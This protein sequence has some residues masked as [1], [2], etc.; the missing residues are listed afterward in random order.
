MTTMRRR[1]AKAMEAPEIFGVLENLVLARRSYT[2][3]R[4]AAINR[5][6]DHAERRTSQNSRREHGKKNV[7][8]AQTAPDRNRA[9]HRQ[10]E[11][12][13]CDSAGD[14]R[15]QAMSQEPAERATSSHG[16]YYGYRDRKKLVTWSKA[17][18]PEKGIRPGHGRD[19]GPEERSEE[20]TAQHS[21]LRSG[22]DRLGV[23]FGERPP[24]GR[25]GSGGPHQAERHSIPDR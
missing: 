1:K 20:N 19:R 12:K 16:Q 5:G 23:A 10:H 17:D 13:A 7:P 3:A 9:R 15:T 18:Q 21:S 14:S 25:A 2:L 11:E 22:A 6:R 24:G 4:K 8:S